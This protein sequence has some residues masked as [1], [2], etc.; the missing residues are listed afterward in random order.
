MVTGPT[1]SSPSRIASS[2]ALVLGI[3]QG[4][5]FAAQTAFVGFCLFAQAPLAETKTQTIQR[6]DRCAVGA[7]ILAI[8]GLIPLFALRAQAMLDE[9][10]AVICTADG[11]LI[12][13][14]RAGHA[15]EAAFGLSTFALAAQ[16]WRRARLLA[17]VLGIVSIA[18]RLATSHVVAEEASLPTIG[19]NAIHVLL[20]A[21]WFGSLP[22]LLVIGWEAGKDAELRFVETLAR[23]S[24]FAFPSMLAILG[25][26]FWLATD[27]VASW[28][29]LFGTIYGLGLLVKLLCVVGVL[30][31]AFILRRRLRK[32][33]ALGLSAGASPV[34]FLEVEFVFAAAVVLMAAA[35]S[36]TIPAEHDVVIWP[37]PFRFAPIVAL[38]SQPNAAWLAA[39]GGATAVAAIALSRLAWRRSH[40]A[41][42]VLM[43]AG[44]LAA[45]VVIVIPA[46]SVPAYP[47]TY[48]VPAVPYDA[49][50]IVRGSIIYRENCA[51]CHGKAGHA[52]GPVAA[53]M[54][55]APADLTQ[56]HTTYHTMGDMF[57]W[58]SRGYP[59]AAMPGFESALSIEDR[60]AVVSYVMA[61]S[62]GYQARVIGPEIAPRQPWLHAIDFPVPA[63]RQSAAPFLAATM[64]KARLLAIISSCGDSAEAVRK[65]LAQGHA[66]FEENRLALAII[67]L[68]SCAI[69]DGQTFVVSALD[70]GD[71]TSEIATAWALYRRSFLNA[72]D[73][74]SAGLPEV[75]EF[76]IDRFGFVRARWRSDENP[77]LV[78]IRDLLH[79]VRQLQA[80]PEINRRSAHDH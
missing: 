60:W 16:W 43:A 74:D 24:K 49:H 15:I 13:G 4:A 40:S 36:Q 30:A 19:A 17:A 39:A 38:A 2:M 26:G 44:A 68:A 37:F 62:L 1:E 53:G 34:N 20:A 6:L 45:A 33:G 8:V 11:P 18:S 28:P 12:A 51:I 61:L 52:D 32:W 77:E 14:T 75:T 10:L 69:A 58:V 56:P 59:G 29:R 65:T 67:E 5:V 79:A 21:L 31:P 9:P 22:P 78:E 25:T 42:A 41:Q 27:T 64:G 66:A 76:L 80:E 7:G 23:F 63:G 47:T 54:K 57:W 70:S 3:V 55:P 72:D 48:V 73:T 35:I 50:V 71:L 46:I